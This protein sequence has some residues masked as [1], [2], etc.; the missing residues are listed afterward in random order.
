MGASWKS[1]FQMKKW[2][3]VLSNP[4]SLEAPDRNFIG[5]RDILIRNMARYHFVA[6]HIHGALLEV[7]CGR[8]Y[9]LE[10]LATRSTAQ[11]GVD[12][13]KVFLKEAHNYLATV[14]FA[15]ASGAALP[16]SD[17]SFDSIIAFDVIEH[18]D[19][20]LT[21]LNE[22][23]RVARNQ[24]FIAISTPNK[25]IA[26]GNGQKPLDPFHAR[27]YT[28]TEFYSLLNKVFP[29]VELFGQ[30]ETPGDAISGLMD[31][32]PTRWKYLVPLSIQGIISVALRPPLRLEEC[33]FESKNL[34]D[35]HTFIAVCRL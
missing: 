21:F 9:G 19:D 7:G 5:H 12:F 24:A 6:P 31:R 30:Y 8:G 3:S 32:I 35:A 28:S 11:V 25:L 17:S 27:E 10:V 16:F 23:K 33:R 22:L 1:L 4:E 20:D 29:L 15:Q 2:L 34:E 14:S 13:S 18:I 26:S